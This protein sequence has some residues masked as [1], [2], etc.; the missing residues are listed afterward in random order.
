M[1]HVLTTL[2]RDVE[3]VAAIHLRSLDLKV[4]GNERYLFYSDI[5]SGPRLADKIRKEYPQLRSRIPEGGTGDGFPAPLAKPDISKFKAV[6]GDGWKGWWDS[7]KGTVE[8]I[9][10]YEHSTTEK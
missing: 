10:A 1:A 6:F 4:P 2:D 5:L 8:D 3:D 7:A 9:L